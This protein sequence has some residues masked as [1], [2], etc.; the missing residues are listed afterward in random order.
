MFKRLSLRLQWPTMTLSEVSL[1]GPGQPDS[2]KPP[3]GRQSEHRPQYMMERNLINL[4][5][6]FDSG[7][8]VSTGAA[9]LGGTT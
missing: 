6:S 5:F 3:Q 9:R 1:A 7:S 4:K 2:N 8:A